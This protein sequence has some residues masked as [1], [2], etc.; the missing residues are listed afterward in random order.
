MQAATK[1]TNCADIAQWRDE[2]EALLLSR[3][4]VTALAKRRCA[5]T[6]ISCAIKDDVTDRIDG[7]GY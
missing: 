7:A 6:L 5:Q 2:A 4:D 3:D 1:A